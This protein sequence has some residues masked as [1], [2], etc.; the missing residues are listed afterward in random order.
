[1]YE[2][3]EKVIVVL[4]VQVKNFEVECKCLQFLVEILRISFQFLE[5]EKVEL[6]CKFSDL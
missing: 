4:D 6:V 1:M 5:D 3:K 2:E